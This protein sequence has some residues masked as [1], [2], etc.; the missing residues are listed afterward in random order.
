MPIEALP[1]QNFELLLVYQ[2][3]GLF[4]T[5]VDVHD[6][7]EKGEQAVFLE[8]DLGIGGLSSESLR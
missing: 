4:V 1:K 3:M 8:Q 7:K 6:S 5:A 2:Q